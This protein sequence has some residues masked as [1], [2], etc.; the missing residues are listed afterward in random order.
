MDIINYKLDVYEG[1]LDVLLALCDKIM[2]LSGGRVSGIVDAR[3]AT[4]E[5]AQKCEEEIN[6]R[7]KWLDERFDDIAR[8]LKENGIL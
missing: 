4:K 8:Q 5:E 2:V 3:K 6:A 7:N 1:P